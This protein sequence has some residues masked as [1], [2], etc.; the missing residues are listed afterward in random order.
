MVAALFSV[1]QGRAALL[2]SADL[3]FLSASAKPKLDLNA[4]ILEQ[5][6]RIEELEGAFAQN[7]AAL[8][9]Q[10]Q[11]LSAQR[12]GLKPGDEAAITQFN[13]AAAA[14]QAKNEQHKQ[15]QLELATAREELE[16]RLAQR[17]KATAANP[18]ATTA[19][20]PITKLGASP[21]AV[22]GGGKRVVIYTTAVC[23]AC[24]K[25]KQYFAQKGVSYQEIDVNKDTA[26]REAFQKLGGRG[27]PLILIGDKRLE[28]F[29]AQALDAAL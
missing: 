18:A 27:V 19:P 11:A 21:A 25:A 9:Q 8:A 4:E 12:T 3:P 10:F 6:G 22:S 17:A 23:P 1:P 24:I 26:G 13:A 15:T 5:R 16:K 2:Q 20:H 29:S 14:Y 28:G 7:G